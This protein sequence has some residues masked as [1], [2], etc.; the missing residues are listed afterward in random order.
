LGVIEA[1]YGFQL[2]NHRRRLPHW[3]RDLVGGLFVDEAAHLLY[4]FRRILGKLEPRTVDARLDGQEIRDLNA[5][6]DHDSIWAS[7]SM[8]RS[9][10]CILTSRL[11]ATS[12]CFQMAALAT[13][14]NPAARVKSCGYGPSMTCSRV[15]LAMK[16]KSRS[17]CHTGTPFSIAIAA[18]RQSMEDRIV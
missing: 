1:A 11:R 2:S 15:Y 3:Y 6:F 9:R 13:I 17:R 8:R 14:R 16:E 18:I 10:H 12:P 7:L 4:L 5:T